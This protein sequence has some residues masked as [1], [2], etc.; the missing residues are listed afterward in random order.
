MQRGRLQ[1]GIL[2][3]PPAHPIKVTGCKFIEGVGIEKDDADCQI[4]P[5]MIRPASGTLN[6]KHRRW[7]PWA[8]D[9][10][11]TTNAIES[12]IY[13]EIVW[14]LYYL[15]SARLECC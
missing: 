3:Q 8:A 10:V 11:I 4:L 6:Q 15:F 14:G 1:F 2:A 12:G 9:K 7:V 5:L 13:S